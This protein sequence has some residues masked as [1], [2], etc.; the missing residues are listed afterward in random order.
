MAAAAAVAARCCEPML[1]QTQNAI[2]H[3]CKSER[4]EREREK[5]KLWVRDPGRTRGVLIVGD[6]WP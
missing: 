5:A 3:T 2:T 4:A 1:S 6:A